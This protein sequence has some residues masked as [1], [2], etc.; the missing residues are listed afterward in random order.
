MSQP[1]AGVVRPARESDAAALVELGRRFHRWSHWK[2]VAGFDSAKAEASVRGWIASPEIAV[3][4]SDPVADAIAL[5]LGPPYFSDDPVVLEIA[6]WAAGGRG[7][8]LRRAGEAW[9]RDRGAKAC[10]MGAH[11][12][13]ETGRI[14][15]WY[16]RCGYVPFGHTHMKVLNHGR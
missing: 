5:M 15:R 7:D 8:A 2:D 12:P 16:A 14:G 11:E 3:F 10:I 6:F 4:V 9:A 1:L 13:G